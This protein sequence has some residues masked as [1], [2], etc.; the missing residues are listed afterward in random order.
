[1]NHIVRIQSRVRL[2]NLPDWHVLTVPLWHFRI[3][4]G[5]RLA[6][7]PTDISLQ[8]LYGIILLEIIYIYTFIQIADNGTAVM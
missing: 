6:S 7:L 4:S 1:M 8:F 5:I 2:T 3:Q